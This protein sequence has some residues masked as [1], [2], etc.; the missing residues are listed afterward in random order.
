MANVSTSSY[1]QHWAT[2]VL[3]ANDS[4]NPRPVRGMRSTWDPATGQRVR[5]AS[6]A[7]PAQTSHEVIDLVQDGVDPKDIEGL[8]DVIMSDFDDDGSLSYVSEDASY[9]GP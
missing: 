8:N 1:G 4:L 2:S 5:H 9:V 6:D 7:I 3:D